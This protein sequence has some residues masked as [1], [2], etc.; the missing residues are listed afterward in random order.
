MADRKVTK[1]IDDEAGTITFTF[2]TGEVEV[3]DV[4]KFSGEIQKQLLLHGGSQKLG[5]S[6]SGEDADKC[7]TIFMGVLKNLTDGN[8]SARSGG[9]GAPR[10]SQLAEALSRAVDQTVE[11][12]VEKLSAMDDETKKAVRGHPAVQSALAEIKLEKATADAAKL[13]EELGGDIP[14][15]KI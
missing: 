1:E 9:G 3:V 13:K 8:W 11:A 4:S 12:C 10:I 14:A 2:A 7:H 5:D 15:L 6:Y